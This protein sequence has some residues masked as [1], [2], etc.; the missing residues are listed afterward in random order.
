M[1]PACNWA[2]VLRDLARTRVELADVAAEIRGNPDVAFPI[3]NRSFFL[4]QVDIP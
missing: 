4:P 2:W 3:G 1:L